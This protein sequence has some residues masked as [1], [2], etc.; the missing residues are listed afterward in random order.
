M[1]DKWCTTENNQQ[2]IQNKKKGYLG[3]SKKTNLLKWHQLRKLNNHN[4]FN[5]SNIQSEVH[6]FYF[7]R[8]MNL[9]EKL[10]YFGFN[11]NEP[12]DG[13]HVIGLNIFILNLSF[14]IVFWR[15]YCNTELLNY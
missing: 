10:K 11:F 1:S 12:L 2:E 8:I 15:N 6:F 13:L 5:Q 7:L 14:Y 9:D 3:R 4:Y